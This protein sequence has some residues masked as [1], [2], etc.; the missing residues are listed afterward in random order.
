[1]NRKRFYDD[2]RMS[3]FGGQLSQPQVDGMEAI[4]DEWDNRGLTDLSWLSYILATVYHETGR[5][6]QPIEEYGK[7][8]RHDYG[9]PDV[10]TGQRYYGRGYVQLTHKRNYQLFADRLGVDLVNQPELALN[11]DFAIKILFDGMIGGLFTGIGLAQYRAKLDWIAARRIVNGR[12]LDVEIA[13]YAHQFF[14]ALK[15]A[16]MALTELTT[17]EQIP[18]SPIQMSRMP[19]EI[20]VKLPAKT[21]KTSWFEGKKT[22]FGMLVSGGLGIAAM[23]GYIP[24][25]TADQGAAMLQTAFGVSGF[26]SALPKL[27]EF[28]V[29]TYVRS[30]S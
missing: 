11:P 4:L 26:R 10:E 2:I 12:D 14:N 1:M 6:M 21:T 8:R 30:K 7:G 24:G 9:Q 16:D 18:E 23:L 22:H 28:A 25:M 13:R 5:T 27:I 17:P 15:A 19:V 29:M 3:L 20:G